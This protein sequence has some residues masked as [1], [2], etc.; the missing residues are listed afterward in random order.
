MNHVFLIFPQRCPPCP[1]H[2]VT[3]WAPRGD[4]NVKWGQPAASKRSSL[5]RQQWRTLLRPPP[6]LLS[7][8]RS[9]P[10][11]LCRLF[12]PWSCHSPLMSVSRSAS[13]SSQRSPPLVLL[14]L[15]L[16]LSFFLLPLLVDGDG[17]K[18][19]CVS[20]AGGNIFQSACFH[21]APIHNLTA[22]LN[23][24]ASSDAEMRLFDFQRPTSG[25]WRHWKIQRRLPLW[26]RLYS[27]LPVM[28]SALS[29]VFFSPPDPG[30][31]PSSSAG[32]I[33]WWES[34]PPTAFSGERKLCQTLFCNPTAGPRQ[35]SAGLHRGAPDCLP[36]D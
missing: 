31:T 5:Y 1:R 20:A 28:V 19:P 22:A 24:A 27:L 21:T 16:S 15:S 23:S 26:L 36:G 6:P 18:S 30:P 14:L 10:R 8:T 3:E 7:P 11:S 2:I 25:R 33:W 32:L 17:P 13:V 4:L 9:H 35:T 12:S 29:C 34:S